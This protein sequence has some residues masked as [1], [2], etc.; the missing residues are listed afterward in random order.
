MFYG[1][2]TD[3]A[4]YATAR[5]LSG[6]PAIQADGEAL[7][8]RASEALDGAYS[9]IGYKTDADQAREWPRYGGYDRAG[10][11]IDSSTVPDAVERAA[12]ALGLR[13][14]SDAESL[15]FIE[16]A[17]PIASVSAGSV[18]VTYKGEAPRIT[19]RSLARHADVSIHLRGLTMGSANNVALRKT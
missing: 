9:F 13:L 14:V 5:G 3:A 7:L 2:H 18:S 1:S 6:W 12:Y 11:L 8:T 16:G 15:A 17:Q 4:A 19:T 10:R